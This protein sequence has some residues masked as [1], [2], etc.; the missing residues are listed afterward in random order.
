MMMNVSSQSN[1]R[2]NFKTSRLYEILRIEWSK[3]V[4]INSKENQRGNKNSQFGTS[5]INKDSVDKKN[6]T[7]RLAYFFTK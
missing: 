5:W 4:S 3:T 1:K 6:K 2:Q 7:N